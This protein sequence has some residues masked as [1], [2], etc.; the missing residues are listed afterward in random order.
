MIQL[1]TPVFEYIKLRKLFHAKIA[2]ELFIKLVI[3]FCQV[4]DS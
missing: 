2:I 1:F 3:F 4:V